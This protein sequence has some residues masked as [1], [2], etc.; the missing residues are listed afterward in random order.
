MSTPKY[1][2][3][4]RVKH[5]NKNECITHPAKF[6]IIGKKHKIK[7]C[8]YGTIT[9]CI[10]KTNRRNRT[11]FY[12]NVSWDDSKKVSLHSQNTLQPAEEEE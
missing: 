1:Q 8:R 12:Y 9:S 11:Y 3:Q 2:I 10:A 7:R 6:S 4:D 5:H